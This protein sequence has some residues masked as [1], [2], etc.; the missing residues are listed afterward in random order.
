MGLMNKVPQIYFKSEVKAGF[1]IIKLKELFKNKPTDHSS[2]KPHRLSFF[3]ILYIKSTKSKLKGKHYIDFE[4]FKFVSQN[5]LFISNDQIHAFDECIQNFDG[6]IIIFNSDFIRPLNTTAVNQVYNY[7]LY[8]PVIALPESS[9]IEIDSL[10]N[11][12]YSEH[13]GSNTEIE[14][15]ILRSYLNILL[16]KIIP[17]RQTISKVEK[18]MYFAEFLEF[19]NLLKNYILKDRSVQ[20][21]AN[22]MLMSTKK[23]NGIC[24]AIVKQPAKAYIISLLILEIKRQLANTNKTIKEICYDTG[25]DEPTNFVK[26]FK[27][28]ANQLPL[29][30]RNSL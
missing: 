2:F 16:H 15:Q 17:L 8:K 24:Q 26:F 28:Y 29:E 18:H 19:Q 11:H 20:F 7:Q 3:A 21:Y 6:Y 5:L 27:K 1:E 14:I 10:F 30:F 22:E 4:E 12:I 25:F 23:L 9:A 13:T